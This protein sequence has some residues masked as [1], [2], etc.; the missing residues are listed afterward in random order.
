MRA[1]QIAQGLYAIWEED[2]G[3]RTFRNNA[4][5]ECGMQYMSYLLETEDGWAALGSLPACMTDEWINTVKAV[6]ADQPVRWSVL[7]GVD[8]DLPAFQALRKAWPGIKLFCNENTL[9]DFTRQGVCCGAAA[10]VRNTKR[11]NF[12]GRT[13]ILHVITDSHQIPSLSVTDLETGSFFNADAFGADCAAQACRVSQL[14][15]QQVWL[16]GA[17][18]Y[19]GEIY[20]AQ[21]AG[22][23]RQSVEWVREN[24]IKRICPAFGPVADCELEK[25]LSIY[26]QP[27]KKKQG[28][29]RVAVVYA[30]DKGTDRLAV[31]I[32]DGL[33]ECG[34]LDVR[35]VDLLHTGREDALEIVQ[36]ADALLLGVSRT[37]EGE[38]KGIWDLLTSLQ[39]EECR[40]KL[41]AVFHTD[42]IDSGIPAH[43]RARLAALGFN[44]NT[45]DHFTAGSP[46]ETEQKAAYEYGFDFSC[47]VRGV[48]NPRKPS[49]VKCLVC[50]EIFDAALGICPVC[51]V[52]LDQCVPVPQEEAAFQRDSDQRYIIVGG[53]TAGVSAAEAIRLRDKTGT[54]LLL[55][56]EKELPIN[57]PM[58]TKNLEEIRSN[59][60]GLAIHDRAWYEEKRIEIHTG[61][62]VRRVDAENR[63]VITE[64]GECHAY[65]KLI[66]AAGAECFVPPFAGG[67]KAGVLTI[68]HLKDVQNLLRLLAHGKSAV[69]IGGGVIGLEV[70]SELVRQGVKVT[71]LEATPQIIGRQIDA[72]SAEKLK[73]IMAAMGVQCHEGVQIAEITGDE[74]AEGVRLA[75]GRYFS[76]DAVIVSCGN[77]ANVAALQQTGARVNR[78]I[79]VNHRMETSLPD[80]YACGDCA[81]L[82]N[83]NYQLWQEAS[84]QGKTA[85]ANAAG[86]RLLYHNEPMG[87]NL[88]AFGTALY[89]IGDPGKKPGSVYETVEIRDR[90]RGRM[91]TYWYQGERLEGA[92]LISAPEKTADVFKAVTTHALYEEITG[93]K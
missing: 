20:G 23:M 28:L 10:A 54:I 26:M 89:A 41:A 87:L 92:V 78:S 49:L 83:V 34:A 60:D 53:G 6:A 46:D 31:Q 37:P 55:S 93:G 73:R 86:D 33:R 14:K 76:A 4:F 44:G 90:V 57:R 61:T 43:I 22:A 42:G 27:E 63:Q 82:E 56:A 5:T 29:P 67:D 45:R 68:R 8:G 85:G 13:L 62:S 21:R 1:E 65:D 47:L 64:N 74:R 40:G 59:P 80:V 19:Y 3:I 52:G 38:N 30:N 39:P 77:R 84:A 25:L 15:D 9:H 88:E 81:E 16:R 75:D 11:L 72:A 79:V 18:I 35:L 2:R 32:A 48:P 24:G 17:Q 58:L 51:G 69:I 36:S 70:A 91:E 12:G 71:V 66:W 50:G 7:F